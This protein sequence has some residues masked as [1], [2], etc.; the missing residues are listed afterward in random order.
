MLSVLYDTG[1]R[2]QELIDLNA[3]DLVA[4]PAVVAAEQDT[5][6]LAA[7]AVGPASSRGRGCS[8]SIVAESTR[9][10][11]WTRADLHVQFIV[12]LSSHTPLAV[13]MRP[14]GFFAPV[15]QSNLALE[16]LVRLQR[17]QAG[18]GIRDLA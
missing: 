8:F 11:T 7:F 1:A 12:L 15:T 17:R 2:V 6:G 10:V 13:H 14:E 5:A 3:N 4:N 18:A 9:W 16:A